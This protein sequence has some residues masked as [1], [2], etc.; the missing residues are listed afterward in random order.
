VDV[1]VLDTDVAE[2]DADPEGDPLFLRRPGIALG[3]CLLHGES[4]RNR[5]DDARE[6]DQQAVADRLDDAAVVLGDLGIDK[7][8]AK[9]LEPRERAFPHQPTVARDIGREDRRQP[10]LR[11]L[12]FHR[13][14]P[15]HGNKPMAGRWG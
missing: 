3:H 11:P 14:P 12:P 10:A 9:R 7:F 15:R 2:V 4:A 13:G 8:A 6:L 5:L 1:T